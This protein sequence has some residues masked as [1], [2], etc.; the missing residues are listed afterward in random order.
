MLK[1]EIVSLAHSFA[2]QA[3][4]DF[5][6]QRAFEP[7][8]RKLLKANPKEPSKNKLYTWGVGESVESMTDDLPIAA[9]CNALKSGPDPD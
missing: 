2:G 6:K 9:T 5:S 3:D 7:L 4:P 8:I 1:A